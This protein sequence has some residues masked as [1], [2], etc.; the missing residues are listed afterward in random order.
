M[1]TYLY[2]LEM[3]PLFGS[4]NMTNMVVRGINVIK[5]NLVEMIQL[6]SLEM[7]LSFSS[8]SQPRMHQF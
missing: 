5:M 6:G 3:L 4:D 2:A 8:I 1:E 7:R